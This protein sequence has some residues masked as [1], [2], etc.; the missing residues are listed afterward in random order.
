Q[1]GQDGIVDRW[2][3]ASD[4]GDANWVNVRAIRLGMVL[5]GARGSSQSSDYPQDANGCGIAGRLYPLGCSFVQG[6]VG[7][8]PSLAFAPPN[9]GRMR[10]VYT[11]T[12]MLRNN[13]F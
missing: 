7:A 3:S 5:R 8:D 1:A 6:V 4:V 2:V 11:T 12:L 13:P 10:R 9:D